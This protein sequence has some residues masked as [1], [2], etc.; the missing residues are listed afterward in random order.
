MSDDTVGFV[1]P[2]PYRRLSPAAY[3]RLMRITGALS[4]AGWGHYTGRI[5]LPQAKEPSAIP[6]I[7]AT[8]DAVRLRECIELLWTDR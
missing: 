8:M 1:N 7:Q 5:H 4:K 2:G 6:A 3:P